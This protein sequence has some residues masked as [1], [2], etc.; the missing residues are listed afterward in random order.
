MCGNCGSSWGYNNIP[1]QTQLLLLALLLLL[2]PP[3]LLLCCMLCISGSV[4][5]SS[6]K[7]EPLL[8]AAT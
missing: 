3:P 6:V 4:S 7:Y 5:V 8:L 1:K 2:P